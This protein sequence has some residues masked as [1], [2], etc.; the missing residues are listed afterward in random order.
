MRKI[1]ILFAVLMLMTPVLAVETNR[2]HDLMPHARDCFHLSQEY[3]GR[4][5]M[6]YEN[7]TWFCGIDQPVRKQFLKIELKDDIIG[8]LQE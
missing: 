6:L 8:T 7:A 2:V 3:G 1:V 5:I 4:S